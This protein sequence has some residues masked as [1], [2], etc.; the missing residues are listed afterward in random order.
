MDEFD[1]ILKGKGVWKRNTKTGKMEPQ[2]FP[3]M[4]SRHKEMS[5]F[6]IDHM[7]GKPHKEMDND[8]RH[9]PMDA[10]AEYV[11]ENKKLRRMFPGSELQQAKQ[12]MNK[13]AMD[14][15][16]NK[17][18]NGDDFNTVPIPFDENGKLHGEYKTNHYGAHEARRVPTA[19][20]KTRD[21]SGKLI[22]LHFNSVAHPTIGRFLE[23]AAFHFEK[24]FR[25]IIDS[26]GID[27]DLGARQNVI[28]PQQIVRATET[29]PDGSTKKNSVLER[30][31]SN[32]KSPED[33][34]NQHFPAFNAAKYNEKA[35]YGQIQPADIVASLPDAFFV[36]TSKG[37][38]PHSV[39]RALIREGI[40]PRRAE[41]MARA[42]AAQLIMG[43]GKKGSA[44]Q[45][46]NIVQRIQ[47]YIGIEGQ[48]KD[49]SIADTY[50]KHR[51]HFQ[52]KV[53]GADRGRT[54]AATRILATL[55]TAEELGVDISPATGNA[56]APR[57]VL[58]GWKSFATQQG[59]QPIDLAGMGIAQEHHQMQGGPTEE[60]G[61]LHDTLPEHISIGGT[62]PM[63]GQLPPPGVGGGLPLD[64]QG[65]QQ[66]SPT[67]PCGP[68]GTVVARNDQDPQFK[69]SYD[70]P[71]GAIAAVMERVQIHDTWENASVMK[72]VKYTNLNPRNSNDMKVLAKQL[73]LETT[74][75]RAIAMSVGDW[76]KLAKHFQ[77]RR[78]VVD[79]IKASC[80]EALI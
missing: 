25:K 20:R 70:D 21:E 36:P 23:S 73:D 37:R 16:K 75:V 69:T 80:L 43:R 32:H 8:V 4:D 53:G 10:A 29:M 12:I 13:A 40:S 38:P 7:T 30:F 47:Q 28:E 72:S 11:S 9:W 31:T 1:T 76:T 14:F 51:S 39:I 45:L 78:D 42:P 64:M 67:D 41:A 48:N 17:R 65:T 49:N 68:E 44:T 55:K 26:M 54:D 56:I 62:D 57:S 6:H 66:P 18:N 3:P 27:S 61:H 74:D 46:N 63:T 71:M 24:E 15:N 58:N 35:Q 33:K 22:N 60:R 50:H 5:H 77:V 59:G 79:I 52:G 34:D 19:N 2:S